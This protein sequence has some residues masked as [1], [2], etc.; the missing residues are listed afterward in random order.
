MI[1]VFFCKNWKKYGFR[2]TEYQWFTD[3][4]TN[5]SQ[6]V[7]YNS[8][9]SSLLPIFT[10][11]PQGSILG[12]LLFII[13][14]NDLYS[15]TDLQLIMYADDTCVISPFV[16]KYDS[17]NNINNRLQKI[18]SWLASNKLSLNV[19]KTKCMLF[20][21]K[22]KRIEH[23]QIPHISINEKPL[24]LVTSIKFLGVYLDEN[25]S[26]EQH[27]NHT[28]NAISK[29]N[30]LL[31]KLKHYFPSNTLLIIYNSLI[32]SR[33]NFGILSWGFGNCDR[34]IT[35]QKRLSEMSINLF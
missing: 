2:N 35:L 3:Y 14:V 23:A 28:A 8:Q 7:I 20:H 10:G 24:K 29:V 16:L 32:L 1:I 13:Y 4:L 9:S 30:G 25:L 19:E 21:F 15:I 5:R 17:K 33:L 6:Y 34:I 26:W 11:V 27:I 12:P 31:S 18:A 22:Q